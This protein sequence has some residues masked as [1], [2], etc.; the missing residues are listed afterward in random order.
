MGI[1]IYISLQRGKQK[2]CLIHW[3]KYAPLAEWFFEKVFDDK[4]NIFAPMS[5]TQVFEFSPKK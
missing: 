5:K 3:H 1:D 2:E 4:N